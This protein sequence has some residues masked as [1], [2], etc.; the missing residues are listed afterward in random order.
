MLYTSNRTISSTESN[1]DDA[2]R[3]LARNNFNIE[4][5]HNDVQAVKCLDDQI[6]LK[7]LQET[8]IDS[9]LAHHHDMIIFSTINE[10]RKSSESEFKVLQGR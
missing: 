1:T 8:N 4:A 2:F 3:L 10:A 7:K 6:S 5:L 9:Y